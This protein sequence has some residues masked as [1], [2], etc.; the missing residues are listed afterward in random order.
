MIWE[1]PGKSYS[2]DMFIPDYIYLLLQQA[3]YMVCIQ[4]YLL[5]WTIITFLARGGSQILCSN[6]WPVGYWDTEL[7]REDKSF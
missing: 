3:I 2:Q 1:G 5:Y 7:G 4:I 6:I